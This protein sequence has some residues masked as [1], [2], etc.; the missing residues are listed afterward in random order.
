[1]SKH[2][3]VSLVIPVFNESETIDRLITTIKAQTFQPL[4]IILVDGGSSDNTVQR[5]KDLTKEFPSFHV[6]EAGRAMPGKG[7]NIGS[8]KAGSEWIAYTDAGIQL[9]SDWLEKLV[10]TA[11]AYPE[12]DIVY[13][14]YAPVIN[15]LFEKCATIAYVPPQL[16]EGVREKFIASCM[17]KKEVWKKSGGFPDGRA[18]EDLVFMEHAEALSRQTVYAPD[19]M[20]YWQLRPGL[21]STYKRFDLYSKYNVWAGRQAYWH[22]GIAKQYAVMLIVMLLS[23]FHSAYWLLLI[24]VWLLARVLKRIVSHKF[25]FG[26]K[27]LFNPLVFFLVLIITL[28]IDAATFAGWAKAIVEKK[29]AS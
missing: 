1:M 6:I 24:P 16:P 17:L 15:N 13:G 8:E 19:A 27:A 26:L 12:A 5:I 10:A 4:E 2:I 25:E 20:L 11:A 29:P 7:R 21:V 3:D 9:K 22:Y 23:V 28:T 14:N 18:A